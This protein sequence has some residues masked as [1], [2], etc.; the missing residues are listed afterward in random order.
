MD[1]LSSGSSDYAASTWIAW[2]L[3]T[4]GNEYFC[5]IDEDYILDRFN[6]TGLNSEVHHYLYALDLITDALDENISDS[7]RDQI[8]TQARILYGLIHARYVVTTRGL[9]KMLDKF[10]RADFGRCPR[11]LCYQQPLLPVGLSDIPFQSPVRL[12]CPRCEDL[13]RPKSSRHCAIDGAFFGSSL[14]HML[15]MVYPHMIPTKTTVIPP[16]VPRTQRQYGGVSADALHQRALALERK[17]GHALSGEETDCMGVASDHSTEPTV[18][19]NVRIERVVPRI[20]GF[21]IHETSR[22][23]A[24]QERK[25]EQQMTKIAEFHRRKLD[26]V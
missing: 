19:P 14:P 25:H 11:V 12:Y 20:F 22:L 23:M 1:E 10:K 3:S 7:N 5:E 16:P 21:P 18:P 2:F 6:L 26:T 24:W 15:L 9:A 8:E 13:Y 4:K 17:S